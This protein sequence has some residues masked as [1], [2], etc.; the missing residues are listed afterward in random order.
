MKFEEILPALREGKKIR[1]SSWEKHEYIR[2][3][4][5][6]LC[7]ENNRELEISTK[8][9]LSEFWELYEVPKEKEMNKYPLGQGF[10]ITG[11]K[12]ALLHGPNGDFIIPRL[13]FASIDS[14]EHYLSTSMFFINYKF[15]RFL[16]EKEMKIIFEGIF[17]NEN[18]NRSF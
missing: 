2:I 11:N 6:Y 18:N 17:E 13:F 1:V 8:N 14:V 4:E 5:D 9:L 3:R 16:E 7:G 12:R 10:I 15:I